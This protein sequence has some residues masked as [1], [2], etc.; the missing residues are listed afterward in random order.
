MSDP[1]VINLSLI[2]HTN[3]GK[4]TLA[5]TLLGRDVGEV[6]DEA[7]VT[8]MSDAYP[9]METPDGCALRLWDTPGFGDTARLAK[10][11]RHSGNP[12]GWMLTQVWDRY[13]DRPLWCSQQAM[14]N[15]RDEADVILYLVNAA[16]APEDAG[17]VALEMEILAW[18]GKPVILLLN[19]TGPPRSPELERAD[20]EAWQRQLAGHGV[21]RATMSLDA[22]ARC[23]VQ[24]GE[25][26]RAVGALLPLEKQGAFAR[27]TQAWR[28]KN[29]ARFHK[30]M[31][32]IARQ[33]A[34]ALCEREELPNRALA[35]KAVG[36]MKALAT[37]SD[38]DRA[39]KDNAMAALAQRLA[40][41]IRAATD[42]LIELHGLEGHAASEIRRRLAADFAATRPVNAGLAAMLGGL[43]TGALGGLAADLAAG[44]FSFG[45]GV[46]SGSVL[47]ALGAGSIARG[48]NL[49]KGQ[50]QASLRWSPEFFEGLLRSAVLRYLAVIHF[51]RG[52][53]DFAESEHPA[54]WQDSVADCAASRREEIRALWERA[55]SAG[56]PA[57]LQEE[58]EA[59]A[60]ECIAGL[61]E[62]FYPDA[63]PLIKSQ[64]S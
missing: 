39:D 41:D 56:D 55:K 54:F 64:S 63:E 40:T 46:V 34:R 53:G 59:L 20:E 15:A 51:G 13:R 31:S 1:R 25:L 16:E 38:P 35:Q 26:L 36:L 52:R 43:V 60:S 6:R 11:L 30:S 48:Y 18:I 45:S 21:V 7:H 2:S 29:L 33:L 27:L 12:V 49:V 50:T 57:A 19:Q 9:M 8:D 28:D 4:T 14:R 37:R 5:R 3:A 22:F 24:E 62:Q 42:A 61:L 17:Y 10:R 32:I 47:G 58:I 44:G 23:W